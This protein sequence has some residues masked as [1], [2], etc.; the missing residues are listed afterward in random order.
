VII[1]KG[2]IIEMLNVLV[3]AKVLCEVHNIKL[4]VIWEHD[5]FAYND[6]FLDALRFIKKDFLFGKEYVYNPSLEP[7]IFLQHI[8]FNANEERYLV[9]ETRFEIIDRR[10]PFRH[11]IIRRHKLYN[12][13]IQNDLSG[14]VVGQ[15]GL[16]DI[17]L[18]FI[19]EFGSLDSKKKQNTTK[20]EHISFE[21]TNSNEYT[22]FLRLLVCSKAKLLISS[23]VETH[24]VAVYASN[25][26][27]IPLLCVEVDSFQSIPTVTARTSSYPKPYEY[28]CNPIPMNHFENDD[29]EIKM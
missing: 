12:K 15:M 13:M 11:Y 2:S 18:N 22:D 23:G 27:M 28:I 24:K 10:V 14:V 20:V 26:F 17:P 29:F 4:F 1:P 9:L 6:L 19:P 25:I 7:S 5:E 16:Y 3:S 21:H 8:E